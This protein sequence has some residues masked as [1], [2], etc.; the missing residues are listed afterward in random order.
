MWQE[1]GALPTRPVIFPEDLTQ[2]EDQ[3]GNCFKVYTNLDQLREHMLELSPSDAPTINSYVNAAWG[4]TELDML[5]APLLLIFSSVYVQTKR[6]W[7]FVVAIASLVLIGLFCLPLF[8]HEVIA[9]VRL[10]TS[11]VVTW[12]RTLLGTLTSVPLVASGALALVLLWRE[13]QTLRE[14][15]L[16]IAFTILVLFGMLFSFLDFPFPTLSLVM[17]VVIGLLGAGIHCD[18]LRTTGKNCGAW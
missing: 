9:N 2:V 11:G 3:D 10:G 7:P 12:D 14:P 5:V 18:K 17:V 4:F 1:L 16:L 15:Y 13:R 8:R 6:L